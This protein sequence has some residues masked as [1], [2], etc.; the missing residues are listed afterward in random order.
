M[1]WL[2][3]AILVGALAWAGYWF[4]GSSTKEG[5]IAGWFEDRRAQ[6]WVAD[7]GALSTRGFPNRF[8][9]TIEDITLADPE[10]GWAWSAPFFQVFALSYRPT[11][12]IAVWPDTQSFQTPISDFE[13]VS[14]GMR[15]SLALNPDTSLSL[16]RATGEVGPLAITSEDGWELRAERGLMA[17]RQ[18]VAEPRA[19]DI[20]VEAVSLRP[21]DA[22]RIGLRT[23]PPLPDTFDVLKLQ[24]T[25]T[26]D[27][28]WDRTAIE[29]ARPQPMKIDLDLAQATW[30]QL[31]LRA[32]GSLDVDADGY[33]TGE[34]TVKASNWREMLSVGVSLGIIPSEISGAMESGLELLA[35]LRGNP[36]TLDLPLTFAGRRISLGPV[37]IGPAP[38][39][40]IR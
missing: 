7:Y 20:F 8:D 2:L 4:I 18:A 38:R 37:P 29:D 40:Q 14:T 34:I 12:V 35:G 23:D 27:K 21:D 24:A 19:Y 9:T 16:A 1:R 15:A 28:V 22:L 30:G 39:F 6:G 25:V 31:A 17:A 33:G 36:E 3:A 32:T 26:F 5:A 13:L 11:Q 10:T